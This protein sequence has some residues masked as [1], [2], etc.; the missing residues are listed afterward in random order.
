MEL[1]FY[2]TNEKSYISI[3]INYDKTNSLGKYIIR[4]DKKVIEESNYK[5]YNQECYLYDEVFYKLIEIFPDNKN[6][7]YTIQ[8]SDDILFPKIMEDKY[9]L[10]DKTLMI[11][12]IDNSIG[13]IKRII[14]YDNKIIRMSSPVSCIYFK[15]KEYII[16]HEVKIEILKEI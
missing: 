7:I 13:S 2:L 1:I 11:D 5:E 3:E 8:K 16:E 6:D 12:E 9:E 4:K 10:L 15:G 14:L